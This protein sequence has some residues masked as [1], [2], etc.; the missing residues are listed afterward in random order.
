MKY[1]FSI[2]IVSFLSLAANAQSLSP[3]AEFLFRDVKTNLS[4]A[5]KNEI[6]KSAGTLSKDRS[7]FR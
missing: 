5:E 1:I 3:E 2:I 7:R 6:A 4:I